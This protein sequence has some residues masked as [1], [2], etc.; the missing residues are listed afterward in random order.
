MATNSP[1]IA[2]CIGISHLFSGAA[3]RDVTC[4]E[5]ARK[6]AF[7][8]T[9]RNWQTTLLT[10]DYQT[11]ANIGDAASRCSRAGILAVLR[12]IRE[13]TWNGG[14]RDVIIYMS[15]NNTRP[16]IEGWDRDINGP[17]IPA[18]IEDVIRGFYPNTRLT[19]FFDAPYDIGISLPIYFPC[20]T[21]DGDADP[22]QFWQCAIISVWSRENRLAELLCRDRLPQA[23]ANAISAGLPI[24]HC[25]SS[26]P[27]VRRILENVASM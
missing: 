18:E 27:R 17:I 10:D 13:Q 2:L 15:A 1:R 4:T 9:D 25:Y 24:R 11:P 20:D 3:P 19:I 16:G 5:R 6:V 8:L 23:V 26:V 14:V 22:M 12:N 21:D 7:S